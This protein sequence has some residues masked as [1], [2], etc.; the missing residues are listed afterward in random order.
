M[1]AE[2]TLPVGVLVSGKGTNLQAILDACA[3]G[4]LDARVVLVLSNRAGVPALERAQRAGVPTVVIHEQ[5]LGSRAAAHAAM[6]DALR[7]SGARL[8]VLAGFD[9]ILHVTFFERLAGVPV[10]NVHPALLPAF[11]GRGMLGVKVHEAVLASGAKES[12]ATVHRAEP[13]KVDEG[14]IVVQRRVPV[15]AGD[16]ADTL[17]ARVLAE[18]HE[19]LVEAIS[20]FVPAATT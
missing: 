20:R 16:T 4:R 5:A 15:L 17:A 1:R 6:A 7:A 14:E 19:A 2:L 18:E 9:R 10:I 8:V 3:G 11:G 13:G 12:G